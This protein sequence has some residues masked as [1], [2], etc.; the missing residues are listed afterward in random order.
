MSDN[1]ILPFGFPVVGCK[2]LIAAFDGGRI[3]CDDGVLL[4]GA[5]AAILCD[6]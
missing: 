3:T 6:L 4:L 2:K 5:V 1:T